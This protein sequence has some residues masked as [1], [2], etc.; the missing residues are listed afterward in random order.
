MHEA[1]LRSGE[2]MSFMGEIS[3]F[4]DSGDRPKLTLN[5]RGK[6]EPVPDIRFVDVTEPAQPPALRA[7]HLMTIAEKLQESPLDICLG[8]WMTWMH[9][10]D[11]DLG[12]KSQGC[13]KGEDS[14]EGYDT[15]AAADAAEM[16]M[17]CEIGAATDAMVDSLDRHFKECIY[18]RCGLV[19]KHAVWRFKNINIFD[20]LPLAEQE[21]AE[22][23]KKNIA[24]RAFF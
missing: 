15:N 5:W 2:Y 16:R 21:L 18:R 12:A 23:L 14:Q 11:R 7:A 1:I 13:I 24:T 22:K 6:T 4:P 9:R 3:A 17:V 8:H 20:T 19:A 10:D